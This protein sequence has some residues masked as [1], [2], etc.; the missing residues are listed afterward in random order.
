MTGLH[1][2]SITLMPQVDDQVGTISRQALGRC[3]GGELTPTAA[4]LTMWEP[5]W[6]PA[7]STPG[8][9]TA[10]AEE[11][12]A[13]A[14]PPPS[15]RALS[16]GISSARL[17]SP[18]CIAKGHIGTRRLWCDVVCSR[19]ANG[20]W[21]CNSLT[22]VPRDQLGDPPGEM[23]G[24]PCGEQ[25]SAWQQRLRRPGLQGPVPA[26]TRGPPAPAMCEQV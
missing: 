5:A 17:C 22:G 6:V 26:P 9:A 2:T 24:C 10:G 19:L 15:P 16:C 18:P 8:A 13:P 14:W 12:P 11:G 1:Q 7:P 21:T 25:P 3:M 20:Q 4:Q 23:W